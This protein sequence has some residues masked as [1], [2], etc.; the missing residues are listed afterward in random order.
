MFRFNT[1]FELVQLALHTRSCKQHHCNPLHTDRQHITHTHAHTHTHTRTRT[2]RTNISHSL[3]LPLHPVKSSLGLR[4]CLVRSWNGPETPEKKAGKIDIEHMSTTLMSH[5]STNNIYTMREDNT[6]THSLTHSHIRTKRTL[7]QHISLS[8]KTTRTHTPV[9]L[10]HICKC[11]P[12]AHTAGR[13]G[14]E[15]RRVLMRHHLATNTSV[16][17][18]NHALGHR[19]V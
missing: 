9:L 12:E 14:V 19:R 1:I 7:A 4:T 2:I 15:K 8:C 6:H 16:F 13:A 10:S 11:H 3:T 18:N 17:K 5:T